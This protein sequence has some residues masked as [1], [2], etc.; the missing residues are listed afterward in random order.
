MIDPLDFSYLDE[1]TCVAAGEGR[2]FWGCASQ[3]RPDLPALV[4]V[5]GGYMGAWA[6]TA[7][8][9]YFD[10][11]GLPAA[12]VDCRGHGGLPQDDA[13]V[14]AGV[15]DYADDV[16]KAAAQFST[17]PILLG[18]SLGALI[19]SVA[20]GRCCI[21]GLGLLAPSPPGQLPGADGVQLVPEDAPRSPSVRLY[22]D[23]EAE[24][25]PDRIRKRLC[26]ESPVALND[27]YGLRVA[28]ASPIG[29]PAIC[30]A[31]GRDD[32]E[33]HPSGQDKAV[34]DFFGA[35]YHV[36]ATA[37]HCFML[38]PDWQGSADLLASWY[39]RA[40]RIAA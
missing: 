14:T 10:K 32:P 27:R 9:R 4:F 6:F 30:V 15:K 5:H 21:S 12:A 36:L 3:M 20:M 29:V 25:S 31:A 26:H 19:A 11:L 35:E 7:Y 24:G 34:G 37:S 16:A 1:L 23:V 28:S 8:L 40:L 17:P 38:T 33:R 13:Y 2:L 22:Q 18:H 39:Q